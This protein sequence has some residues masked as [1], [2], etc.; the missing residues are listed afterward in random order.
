MY[1][2]KQKNYL[3]PHDG[4]LG[5]GPGVV[6]VA[7]QVLGA[8]HVVGSS[9]SLGVHTVE[10]WSVSVRGLSVLPL[11]PLSLLTHL[12]GD[13]GDFRDR[14]LCEG[15]Q[16]LGSVSDDAA[17]LLSRACRQPRECVRDL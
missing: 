1:I 17:V 3:G 2:K 6:H 8:H 16:Q 4:D 13:D 7:S 10:C 5:G 15:V 12:S 11:P 14:G 9:V